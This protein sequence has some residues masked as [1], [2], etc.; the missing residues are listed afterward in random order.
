ML[1]LNQIETSIVNLKQPSPPSNQV[2]I[3][4]ENEII[5]SFN[6]ENVIHEEKASDEESKSD[7][8]H[9]VSSEKSEEIGSSHAFEYNEPIELRVYD[10]LSYNLS[11]S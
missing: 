1:Q 3:T 7:S 6:Y 5:P 2:V 11:Y 10:E 8:H 9:R 4:Q